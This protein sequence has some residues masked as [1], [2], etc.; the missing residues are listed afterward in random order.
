MGYRDKLHKNHLF[1]T[2]PLCVAFF[3]AGLIL[4]YHPSTAL[5]ASTIEAGS[6]AVAETKPASAYGTTR[7]I[8]SEETEAAR[9]NWIQEDDNWYYLLPDGT[10][11]RQDLQF[12]NALYKFNWNGSLK[13]A[14]W[15]PNTGGGAYPVFCYDEETQ[16]LFD[17]LNDEKR[18]LYFEE[19]PDREDEYGNDDKRQYDRYAGFIMDEKLNQAAAHRL[20][21]AL[22][23][24]Y[25]G[26]A[27][28]GEGTL[29]DYLGQISY[30]KN[31]N[32]RE[33]YLRG[34][35][36]AD[37]AFDKLIGKTQ[38]KYDSSGK[39]KDSLDYYR[40]IGMAH[41]EKD[42]EHYFMVILMR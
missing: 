28:P 15:V 29:K 34:R 33:L 10:K 25:S 36:D 3:A 6:G 31:S 8:D 14:Q 26:D 24:G 1:L 30:R 32:C 40:R 42:G 21:M 17:Q 4:L 2:H 41:A 11:N 35:E 16:N 27:I 18:N 37:D 20:E 7:V 19:Y 22:A 39:R 38:D 9:A 13:T 12:D 5:A 23:N